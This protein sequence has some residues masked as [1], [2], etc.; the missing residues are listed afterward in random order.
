MNI[1]SPGTPPAKGVRE[2]TSRQKEECR[3][4]KGSDTLSG[5]QRLSGLGFS[6]LGAYPLIRAQRY[7]L[8]QQAPGEGTLKDKV[9]YRDTFP[10]GVVCLSITQRDQQGPDTL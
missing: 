1:A 7:P 3:R 10:T 8:R 6:S 2:Q 5:I 9:V 4:F